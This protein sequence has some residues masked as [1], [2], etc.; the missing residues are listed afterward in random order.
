MADF[1]GLTLEEG[2]HKQEMN[3]ILIVGILNFT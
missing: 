2:T 3:V 1:R